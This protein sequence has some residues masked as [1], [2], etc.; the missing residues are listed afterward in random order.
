MEQICYNLI[1]QMSEIQKPW[2][3][4][5]TKVLAC[6]LFR[7]LYCFTSKVG[8]WNSEIHHS[9]SDSSIFQLTGMG[10]VY[11][12]PQNSKLYSQCYRFSTEYV[13]MLMVL[14]LIHYYL[15]NS[16]LPLSYCFWKILSWMLLLEKDLATLK[17]RTTP[18]LCEKILTVHP[19]DR[20]K[21]VSK[22]TL[23]THNFPEI[24]A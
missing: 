1:V 18:R 3:A 22:P 7:L 5:R 13:C 2:R 21:H 19:Q 14:K 9:S 20:L 12:P 4:K 24:L 17:A 11:L 10:V 6:Y 8:R 16:I 23:N 15:T